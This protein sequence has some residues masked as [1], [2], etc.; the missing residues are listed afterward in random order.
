MWALRPFRRNNN[1]FACRRILADFGHNFNYLREKGQV[2]AS[3]KE[4][5]SRGTLRT[6]LGASCPEILRRKVPEKSRFC[7]T[8][9][10]HPRLFMR[11]HDPMPL[12]LE[13]ILKDNPR[14]SFVTPW[15]APGA[16][17]RNLRHEY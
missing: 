2:A 13:G 11:F 4:S 6:I 12:I 8:F 3:L 14:P 10:V 17:E 15:M 16:G 5:L 1:P 7:S 9:C